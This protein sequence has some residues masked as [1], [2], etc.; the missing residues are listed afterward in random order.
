MTGRPTL[1]DRCRVPR[2]GG[3]PVVHVTAVPGTSRR[4]N[5]A[6]LAGPRDSRRRM[7][8]DTPT[9]APYRCRRRLD[10]EPQPGIPHDSAQTIRP[11]SRRTLPGEPSRKGTTTGTHSSGQRGCNGAARGG[12]ND[13][14]EHLAHRTSTLRRSAAEASRGHGIRPTSCLTSQHVLET[15]PHACRGKQVY[16]LLRCSTRLSNLPR[17]GTT[18]VL[19]R[20]RQGR[21]SVRPE[22]PSERGRARRLAL[23]C[24]QGRASSTR[25]KGVSVARRTRENPAAVS[26]SRSRVSP[27]CAPSARPTCWARDPGVQ[28]IVDPA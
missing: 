11:P 26:T 8:A 5:T 20:S 13:G 28:S 18:R 7:S 17:A 6:S 24:G 16:W 27:A 3:C 10:G 1:A 9:T 2:G 12:A 21:P 4:Y 25:L 23:R 14:L 22:C 15:A 19:P